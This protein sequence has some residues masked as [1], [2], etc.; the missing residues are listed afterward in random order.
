MKKPACYKHV[1]PSG[2]KAFN[3]NRTRSN[4]QRPSQEVVKLASP[5][6]T[7]GALPNLT[8]NHCLLPLFPR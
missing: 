8:H 6:N 7:V 3:F 1:A 4:A 5:T 2:A